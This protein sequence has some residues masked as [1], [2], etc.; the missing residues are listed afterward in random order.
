M[1]LGAAASHE[2][3]R[4]TRAVVGQML[5]D[6]VDFDVASF[7]AVHRVHGRQRLQAHGLVPQRGAERLEAFNALVAQDYQAP[8]AYHVTPPR[9]RRFLREQEA[10]GPE[11]EATPFFQKYFTPVGIAHQL[12][13]LVFD[14]PRFLGLL[15][16]T[17]PPRTAPFTAADQSRLNSALGRLLRVLVD[18]ERWA[19]PPPGEGELV[20]S[21][22]GEVLFASELGRSWLETSA[23]ADDLRR[24]AAESR[25]TTTTAVCA[26]GRGGATT[27]RLTGATS[28]GAE[29][30]LVR[31][32]PGVQLR[33]R[34]TLSSQQLVLAEHLRHGRTLAAAADAMGIQRE[35]A[36][37][38]LR[39]LYREHDL[40]SRLDLVRFLDALSEAPETEP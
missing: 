6:R 27:V 17:R 19:Q 37:E 14:G 23:T 15:A 4:E 40:H 20:L 3:A 18:G 36:K 38:H 5:F 24:L 12:R 7:S 34:A 9:Q 35:T 2:R 32:T 13:A 29:T 39:R 31:L 8:F 11:P 30:V 28:Q 33:H 16:L 26:D 1:P 10:F 22:D 21:V 25:P